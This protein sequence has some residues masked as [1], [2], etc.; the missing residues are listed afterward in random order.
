MKYNIPLLL[1]GNK[2]DLKDQRA[3]SL[4][5][6]TRFTQKFNIDYI[7]TSAKTRENV[8]EVFVALTK[9]MLFSDKRP[10]IIK[11]KEE[12]IREDSVPGSLILLKYL[13]EKKQFALFFKFF[14]E[15]TEPIKKE[16]LTQNFSIYLEKL[17]ELKEEAYKKIKE[18]FEMSNKIYRDL[19]LYYESQE[20]SRLNININKNEV[21][22]GGNEKK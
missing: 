6:I 13:L 15:L 1:V 11:S 21:I 18:I 14:P 3:V 7:E 12:R 10:L 20:I 16:F 2:S 5:E 4:Q 17:K 22:T 19:N 8:E 9:L